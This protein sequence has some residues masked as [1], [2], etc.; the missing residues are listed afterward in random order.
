MAKTIE[1]NKEVL[2]TKNEALNAAADFILSWASLNEKDKEEDFF[3]Q[4]NE[5]LIYSRDISENRELVLSDKEK[6]WMRKEFETI[7]NII[8]AR[9]RSRS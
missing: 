5:H 2:I 9:K 3:V 7:A 8:R 1:G 4:F 6:E